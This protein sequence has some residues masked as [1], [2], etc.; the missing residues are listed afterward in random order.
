MNG[1]HGAQDSC[2]SIIHSYMARRSMALAP[3]K[4]LKGPWLIFWSHPVV[5][6]RPKL[7]ALDMNQPDIS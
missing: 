2:R 7:W 4:G 6:D 1:P 3:K 5:S